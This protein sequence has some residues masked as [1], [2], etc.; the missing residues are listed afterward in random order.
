MQK[1][2]TTIS[3]LTGL[4][5]LSNVSIADP[6]TV[7]DDDNIQTVLSAHNGKQFR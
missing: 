1:T 5:M 2:L 7:G 3:L 4:L 6:L